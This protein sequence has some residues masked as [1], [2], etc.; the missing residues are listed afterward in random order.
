[1]KQKSPA[2]KA[3]TASVSSNRASLEQIGINSESV[4]VAHHDTNARELTEAM[5]I[6]NSTNSLTVDSSSPAMEAD[7]VYTSNKVTKVSS[8]PSLLWVDDDR[9]EVNNDELD[10]DPNLVAYINALANLVRAS[11]KANVD[12]HTKKQWV[13]SWCQIVLKDAGK[14]Y[15]SSIFWQCAPLEER[16]KAEFVHGAMRIAANLLRLLISVLWFF[17]FTSDPFYRRSKAFECFYLGTVKLTRC[18]KTLLA[19]NII[20]SRDTSPW[21]ATSLSGDFLTYN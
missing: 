3:E 9:A 18:F 15:L 5:N 13:C 20:F 4:N 11:M 8:L 2:I 7:R 6:K 21:R 17:R 1:M 14:W 16:K 19:C 10:I 12:I